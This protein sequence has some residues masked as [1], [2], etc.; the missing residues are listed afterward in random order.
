MLRAFAS[1]SVAAPNGTRG[2]LSRTSAT[3]APRVCSR[4]RR[5]I[6]MP[7]R[8]SL[9]LGILAP[10]Q[11]D[12]L[13]E[14]SPS[15]SISSV[16]QHTVHGKARATLQ[17]V[18]DRRDDTD[19]IY[20]PV[21]RARVYEVMDILRSANAQ[22]DAPSVASDHPAAPPSA[23]E[24]DERPTW[25]EETIGWLVGDAPPLKQRLILE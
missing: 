19:F 4:W 20:V 7:R 23:P 8:E 5:V 14:T 22:P 21:P 11:I 15:V 6:A 17:S 18:H 25:N 12:F 2:R 3:N 9:L 1:H 13:I 10:L 16:S 24:H